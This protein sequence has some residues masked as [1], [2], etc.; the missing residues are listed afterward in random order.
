M[1]RLDCVHNWPEMAQK[2]NWTVGALAKQCNVSVRTLHRHFIRQTGSSTKDWLAE[3]RQRYALKLLLSGSSIKETASCLG[4][5]QPTSFTRKYKQH[6]GV[7]PSLQTF[8]TQAA[9][10][11]NV[12]K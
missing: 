10:T 11:T 9:T 12:R 5:K 8:V 2:A 7:C 1:N 6:W 4:Y 3:Q